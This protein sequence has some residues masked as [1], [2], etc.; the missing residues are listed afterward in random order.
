MPENVHLAMGQPLL[1]LIRTQDYALVLFGALQNLQ[2][3]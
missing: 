1:Y 2:Q 3:L